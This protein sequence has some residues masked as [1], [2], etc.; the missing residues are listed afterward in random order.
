M[1]FGGCYFS[2]FVNNTQPGWDFYFSKALKWKLP[3]FSFKPEDQK[4]QKDQNHPL[5][6]LLFKH[7][8]RSHWKYRTLR[9]T[10]QGR[11]LIKGLEHKSLKTW[12]VRSHPWPGSRRPIQVLIDTCDR[13][14][15]APLGAGALHFFADAREAGGEI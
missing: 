10:G 4:H 8:L 6:L 2:A 1:A 7:I 3:K 12:E 11:I 9:S 15:A 13:G 5:M 14:E